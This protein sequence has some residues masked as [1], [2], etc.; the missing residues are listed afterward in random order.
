MSTRG[1][2]RVATYRIRQV[3]RYF[4]P[5]RPLLASIR[6]RLTQTMHAH[7]KDS[8]QGTSAMYT[9]ERSDCIDAYACVSDLF[10]HEAEVLQHKRWKPHTDGRPVLRD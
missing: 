2:I 7:P 3:P 9:G 6:P 4:A 8:A 1:Q 5:W 10:M